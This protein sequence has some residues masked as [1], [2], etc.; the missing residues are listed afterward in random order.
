[1]CVR[2]IFANVRL[3]LPVFLVFLSTVMPASAS[4]PV[5]RCF[6][7]ANYGGGTQNWAITQDALG[8]MY[9]GNK[10]G[11]LVYDSRA[12]KLYALSNGTTIRSLLLDDDG[13]LYAGGTE[14]F[15]YF[16]N[17]SVTGKFKYHT[18]VDKVHHTESNFKEIWNI[19]R[20]G[21]TLWFQS[22]YV[23]FRY[24][25]DDMVAITTTDKITTS[26]L[27]KGHLFVALQNHGLCELRDRRLEP[28]PGNEVLEGQKICAVM[29]FGQN[30]MVATEFGGLYE[31][32]DGDVSRLETGIDPFLKENQVFTALTNGRQIAFGTVNRGVVIHDIAS[33]ENTYVSIETGLQNNT[34]LSLYFDR[35]DNLWLGLDNGIDYVIY[36]S[37]FSNLFGNANVYGAGYTSVVYDNKLFLGTNQG[38]YATPYPVASSPSIPNLPRLLK[39][40]VWSL[41][42]VDGQLM[43]SADGGLS[44]Y[45]GSGLTRLGGVPGA[46]K[47]LGL[48]HHAGYAM[49]STYDN[50]YLLRRN[51]AGWQSLGRIEGYEDI[52]GNFIE[53]DRG[54]IWIAHWLK[55]VYHLR[56]NPAERKFESVKFYNNER[57]LPSN[58]NITPFVYEGQVLFSTEG[59]FYSYDAKADVMVPFAKLNDLFHSPRSSKIYVTPAGDIWSLSPDDVR[60]ATHSISGETVVD[61]TTFSSLGKRIIP[62]F[63]NFNFIS[64]TKGIVSTQDG[65]TEVDISRRGA[66]SWQ[67]SL[68]VNRVY[69]NGDSLIYSAVPDFGEDLRFELP[70]SLNSLRFEFV[71]PEYRAENAV[72]YSCFLEN[73]D[74]DWSPFADTGAKEYTRLPEGTYTMHVCSLDSYN[75]TYD[76]ESITFTI[77][78]PW[79]RTVWAKIAY[80]ILSIGFCFGV[81]CLV[82]AIAR[83]NAAAVARRNADEM[84]KLRRRSEEEALRKD[85]EIADLK[86]RQLEQDITH[87]SEELS[88]ITMNV[89]RKNE[90]LANISGKLRK[91][92]ESPELQGLSPEVA[93]QFTRIQTM[94]QENMSHDDD[95]RNFTHNFDA[96]YQDFT[97]QLLA[98]HPGLTPTELRVCCYLKMG[99]S[100]KEI[101]QLFNISYRSV[102][103]TRYRLRKKLELSRDVNLTDYLSNL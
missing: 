25:G 4:V 93:R 75:H 90:I 13:K 97:K 74:A 31:V 88:N 67:S 43:V 10:Y 71:K 103:M 39:G 60:L 76:T 41:D 35:S 17:D 96:V 52:G 11:L 32:A 47:A 64:A 91:L 34:V 85:Y 62:G 57:G 20:L 80:L 84:E 53:D 33:G 65:F 49:V 98:K 46:W 21:G 37:P 30:L 12:W 7:R 42:I 3:C 45:N 15:G 29:P 89:V 83:R 24:N 16:E 95:W 69:A 23:I 36:N 22:D 101:A 79:Y 94:I 27:V 77:L 58:Y 6:S 86:G 68:F 63:D 59:G 55:G 66:D 61:T 18:L 72:K 8:R 28:V 51:G 26:A 78:P 48:K 70:Y 38:L 19:H 54:D 82:R 40:Q 92:Q 87:K 73:Y 56:L 14:D 100:S 1:M 44:Y 99:L 2:K 9:F 102:E 81:F 50:F 5:V